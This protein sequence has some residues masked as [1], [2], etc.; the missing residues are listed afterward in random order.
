M[1]FHLLTTLL[2]LP[3]STRAD[4]SS[5]STSLSKVQSSTAQLGAS[6]ASWDGNPL[7]LP[8]KLPILA[9]GISL[10]AEVRKA[11][12]TAESSEPLDFDGAVQVA[13]ATIELGKTVNSTLTAI[14]DAKPKFDKNLLTPLILINLGLQKKATAELSDEIVKKVPAELQ[15]TARELVKPV[16]EGFALAIHV[17]HQPPF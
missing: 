1:K 10:L 6:V 7:L 16:D 9:G 5:I 8:G 13:Q 3:V 17:F 2:L 4:P 12:R 11:T 15:D 14:I